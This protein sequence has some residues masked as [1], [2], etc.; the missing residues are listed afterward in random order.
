V[1]SVVSARAAVGDGG[2]QLPRVRA[3]PG[4]PA[5]AEGGEGVGQGEEHDRHQRRAV[6]PVRTP[7]VV[8]GGEEAPAERGERGE[9][10]RGAQDQ[11]PAGG[12]RQPGQD[13]E[14]GPRAV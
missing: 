3:P 10:Q 13:S 2:G 12:E 5:A 8:V 4:A 7:V 11:E 1:R 14:F 6:V 9:E